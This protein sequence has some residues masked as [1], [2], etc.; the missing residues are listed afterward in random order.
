MPME[1]N[2][3]CV[4]GGSGFVGRHVV[5]LLSG[6]RFHVR[7]PTRQRERAKQLILLPTV[8]VVEA[9]VHDR[10]SWRSSCAAWTR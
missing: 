10:A 4:I 7:V 5:H 1:M 3:V 9:D 8:D 6:E 2:T